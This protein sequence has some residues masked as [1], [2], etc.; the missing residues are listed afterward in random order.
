MDVSSWARA[1][2]CR[3]NRSPKVCSEYYALRLRTC[4]L[5]ELETFVRI[6]SIPRDDLPDGAVLNVY[7]G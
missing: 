7:E 6:L 1:P 4:G 5:F 2:G 3:P